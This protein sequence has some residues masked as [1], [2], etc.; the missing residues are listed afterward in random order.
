MSPHCSSRGYLFSTRLIITDIYNGGTAVICRLGL[1]FPPYLLAICSYVCCIHSGAGGSGDALMA[2]SENMFCLIK[3]EFCC[4]QRQEM[5][6]VTSSECRLNKSPSQGC[7][8]RK[9]TSNVTQATKRKN[10]SADIRESLVQIINVCLIRGIASVNEQANNDQNILK[11]LEESFSQSGLAVV[12][13]A[14]G[15]KR[16]VD[17]WRPL[18]FFSTPRN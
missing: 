4:N 13:T 10:M 2:T 17:C 18:G 14:R 15:H 11:W 16:A 6:T 3:M 7:V 1:L 8:P 5:K 9:T 12:L